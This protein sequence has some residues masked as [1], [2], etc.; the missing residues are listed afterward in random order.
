MSYFSV[1]CW[2]DKTMILLYEEVI[3]LSIAKVLA[4]R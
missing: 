4:N 1:A 2:K 3:F